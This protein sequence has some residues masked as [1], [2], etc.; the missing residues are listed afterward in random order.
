MFNDFI[1]YFT[2]QGLITQYRA[3]ILYLQRQLGQGN[4]EPVLTSDELQENHAK[5][6]RENVSVKI[7]GLVPKKCG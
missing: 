7:I 1:T 4:I 5:L 6:A 2:K 3:K